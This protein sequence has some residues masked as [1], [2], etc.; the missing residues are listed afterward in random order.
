MENSIASSRV[1]TR[2]TKLLPIEYLAISARG[3]LVPCFLTSSS[4]ALSWSSV[5]STVINTDWL[6]LP[7][8]A[9]LN[10][11]A[12][13]YS[14]LALASAITYFILKVNIII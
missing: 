6:S 13:T 11:S 9:W 12:A 5:K 2:N 10:K 7:C 1:L 8:S 4:I 14:G 3:K